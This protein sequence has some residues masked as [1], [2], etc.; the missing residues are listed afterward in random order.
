MPTH[1]QLKTMA[2]KLRIHSLRMTTAAGS[3]HPTTCLSAAE[4]ISVLFFAV[5]G[6]NDEFV[7]SK[8]HAAPIL[9]AALA[10]A[11][12]IP[13]EELAGLRRVDSVLEGHPTARMPLVRVATGSLG[14][15]LAA[16]CG[17]ALAKR[18]DRAPGRVFVLQGDGETAEGSV[19][20]AADYAVQAGLDNLALVIDANR[21]G[22]SGPTRH[23]HDLAA[24][25]RKFRAFGWEAR[26]VDG[27][28]V[29]SLA[30]ALAQGAPGRPLAVIARTFK[31]RGVSFLEDREGWHGKPLGAAELE[32]ALAEIGPADIE[33]PSAYSPARPSFSFR[34]FSAGEYAPGDM[35]ATRAAYGKALLALGRADGRVVAVDGDVKNS[36]MAEEFF[37]AFPGRAVEAYIA[38]QNM[39]GLALGLSAMGFVPW[40]ATFAAF[41]ARA[42]DHIRMAQY[43][44]ANIK[45]VGSHAGVSIGADGP[46]QMGLEDLAL[47]LA[48]PEAMVLYPGDAVATAKLVREMARHVGISYLRTTRDKTPVLYENGE[49]F[50]AGG[51]KVLRSSPADRA[52]VAGCGIT[53][54]EALK[55]HDAL[56]RRGVAVR[57]VD[58]YSLRPLPEAELA[59]HAEECGGRVVVAEDHYGGVIA[60]LVAGVVGKVASLH[61]REIPRSGTSGELLALMKIDSAAI[62]AAVEEL[63]DDDPS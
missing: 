43:S 59:R 42:H 44:G 27:H 34:D 61:V 35:V 37:R 13:R 53:L 14:Q 50:P 9:W 48:M 22:Q 29:A 15:G 54:H 16:G 11:G 7:L 38:E 56:S 26:V 36:T 23:G 63:L 17:M 25:E 24:Y 52:L 19:W 28:D 46:S 12:L 49:E 2:D 5:M 33:L 62:V 55:A 41:L 1:E 32:R 58:L 21:L 57:V 30:G 31:G 40:V 20:E 4:I 60:G 3:G 18:L 8:G 45:F 47:F 51:L 39:A 6:G 10:E